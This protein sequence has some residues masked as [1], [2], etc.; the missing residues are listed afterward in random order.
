[1]QKNLSCF[2]IDND[3]DDQDIFRMALRDVNDQIVFTVA[4]NGVDALQQ[5]NADES[6]VPSII[7]IDM[8]MPLMDGKQCL[9]EIKKLERLS[10]VPIYLYSTSSDPHTIAEVKRLGAT[11]FIVKPAGYQKLI[12][13]LSTLLKQK[14]LN[15]ELQ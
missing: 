1:M 7:F 15:N 5:V 4:D 14:N 11:D 9:R 12:Q 6:Y 2:L 13:L 3:T 8:N 10:R